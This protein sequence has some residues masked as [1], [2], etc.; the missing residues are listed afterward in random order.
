MSQKQG[1]EIRHHLL[2][3]LFVNKEFCNF[4]L[5]N[6]YRVGRPGIVVIDPTNG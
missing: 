5:T 6:A 4:S 1:L 3:V 2:N